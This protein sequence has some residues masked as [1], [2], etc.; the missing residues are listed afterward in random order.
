MKIV[1]S[2]KTSPKLLTKL[3]ICLSCIDDTTLLS[4]PPPIEYESENNFLYTFWKFNSSVV[5]AE[6]FENSK[7]ILVISSSSSLLKT[8]K[9]SSI[10]LYS[11]V[12][13]NI[14]NELCLVSPVNIFF[15]YL[16]L[17]LFAYQKFF[18]LS[19]NTWWIE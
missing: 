1:F 9:I 4:F 12:A 13:D 6:G 2:F 3:S 5:F 15:K 14:S 11:V 10:V 16:S 17:F 19:L 8:E 18:H 7:N